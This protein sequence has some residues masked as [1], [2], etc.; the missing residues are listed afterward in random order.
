VDR[1]ETIM[2]EQQGA[3]ATV[4]LE[5][6]L[7]QQKDAIID[8]A[9]RAA[10]ANGW[11]G[12]FEGAMREAFPEGSGQPFGEW[13]DSDGRTC[14]GM[15]REG[16]SSDGF[17]HVTGLDRTGFNRYQVDA[18]GYSR[19]GWHQDTRLN[20]DGFNRQG[21]HVD[22]DDYR[23]LYR[24]DQAGYAVDGYNSR[25]FDRSGY[26]RD[27][28]NRHGENWYGYTRTDWTPERTAQLFRYNAEGLRAR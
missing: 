13:F 17:H 22:S 14:R 12:Q 24:Y 4:T 19:D 2:S 25:G 21:L 3:T 27:G 11:C 8:R 15:D 18:E 10:R 6:A 1:R 23:A 5:E 7:Q 20:R 16:Y 26:D 9:V 28:F